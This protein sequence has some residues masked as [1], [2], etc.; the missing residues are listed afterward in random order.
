M[1]QSL[2]TAFAHLYRQ[3]ASELNHINV[4]E[5]QL[6]VTASCNQGGGLSVP[7]GPGNDWRCYVYWHLPD[8]NDAT[9]RRST[10]LTSTRTGGTSPTA[11]DRRK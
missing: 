2:A 6:R 3:Q 5:A 1:Q 10:S 7:E 11:T 4:T 8:V 9:D